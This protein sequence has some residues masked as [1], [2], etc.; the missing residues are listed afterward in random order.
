MRPAASSAAQR[1]A[2][3]G[4][5]AHGTPDGLAR[6]ADGSV[7][8][9]DDGSVV[10]NAD[11][12]DTSEYLDLAHPQAP[13]A[14]ASLAPRDEPL[15]EW[16]SWDELVAAAVD[17]ATG[18]REPGWASERFVVDSLNFAAASAWQ[19]AWIEAADAGDEAAANVAFERWQRA[20]E[21]TRE[22]WDWTTAEAE[23]VLADAAR[24]GDVAAMVR[25]VD[26]NGGAVA[27]A[28]LADRTGG[29][30]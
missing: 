21:A 8:T 14:I 29:R 17:V 13:A 7:L 16:T 4:Q 22:S 24:A 3:T 6:A 27:Q 12:V 9:A 15:P 20:L 30:R 26:L 19:V 10:R 23:Q 18:Q 1:G 25:D 5:H 28:R 2:W 11:G